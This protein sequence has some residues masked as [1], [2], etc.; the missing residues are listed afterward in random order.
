MTPVPT[1]ASRFV[2]IGDRRLEYQWHG[3]PPQQAPTIVFLHEGLGAITRWRDF[4]AALCARL[5]WSGLVYNRE[6]YGASDPL[7]KPLL[8]SFMHHEALDVLP[9]LI[10]VFAIET[11][12]LFGHSDGGSIALIY[13]GSGHPV[14]AL[15]LE[16][17]HVFVEPV[18]VNSIAALSGMYRSNVDLRSGLA[19]HHGQQVDRLFTFWTHVWLSDQFRSWNIESYLPAVTCQSLVIQGHDDEYGTVRQVEAIRDGVSGHVEALI[20]DNCGHSP[21]IDR[22]HAVETAAID[23]LQRLTVGLEPADTGRS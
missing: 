16:A 13:A 5:G 12:V 18:T 4:P 21:H 2:T 10:D 8:P 23:F 17:P 22:R 9:R 3:P 11:P 7:G 20:L 1:A 14:R 6:G 19:R 15:V